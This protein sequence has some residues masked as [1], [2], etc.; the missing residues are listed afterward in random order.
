MKLT[1]MTITAAMGMVLL[2]FAAGQAAAQ[3][4]MQAAPNA[5]LHGSIGVGVGVKPE[6]E[7]AKDLKTALMPNINLFY[8][9]AFFLTGM[10]AGANLL[11]YQTGQGVTITAGPILALRAGRNQDDN[12]ALRGLGEI[13]RAL[14]AG[15]FVRLRKQGWQASVDVRQ[16]VTNTGQGATV[17][18]S[19]GHGIPLSPKLRLRANFDTS[20]ASSDYMKTFFAIDALQSAQSGIAQYEAGS[21]F[22]HVGAS[23][24]AD[25]SISRE[26]AGFASVRYKRLLGD[27][28][29]SPIVSSLGDRDQV[30]GSIGIKYR[31]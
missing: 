17:N 9:D 13:D 12:D 2:I 24:M 8:G 28:A 3:E 14:D 16:N 15:G 22:K 31:F 5:G 6:Y 21:G 20:W 19:A 18:F 23:L 7:G 30:S 11:R 29:A 4:D 26:W 25:Y 1:H 10:T 27:A